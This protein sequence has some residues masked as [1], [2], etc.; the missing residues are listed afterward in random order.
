M[1][2][3]QLNSFAKINLSLDVL[4]VLDNGFHLVDMVMQQILLCDDILIKWKDEPQDQSIQINVSTNRYFLPTD[5]RNLAYKA[6]LLMADKYGDNRS[7]K[8]TIDIRKRIPVAAGLAG[9][10]GN[11]AAVLHGLNILWGLELSMKELIETGEQLG[12][13]VPFCVMGQ[14]AADNTLKPRF[15]GD[16]LACHCALATGTGTTLKPLKKGLRSHLV[17]SKPPLSVSTA[18]VYK[19]IDSMIIDRHPDNNELVNALSSGSMKLVRKNMINVL[20]NFT[21]TQYPIVKQTKMKL[22]SLCGADNVLMSGSGPAVF[23]LCENIRRSRQICDDMLK[24]NR[25]SFWTRTTW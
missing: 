16:P 17:L 25:E 15:L 4:G 10:S 21:L 14:A 20:E 22:E 3:I 2:K 24:L 13:D 19:G 1:K 8:V 18:T 12:S 6:A 11:A 5:E 23:G 9:G 7:G